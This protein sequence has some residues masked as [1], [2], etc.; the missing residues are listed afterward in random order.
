MI[1][2]YVSELIRLFVETNLFPK[3]ELQD[4]LCMSEE[5]MDGLL[6]GSDNH[7]DLNNIECFT[8]IFGMSSLQYNFLSEIMTD[9]YRYSET[10][11]SLSTNKPKV[12]RM[13]SKLWAIYGESNNSLQRGIARLASNKCYVSSCQLMMDS[14]KDAGILESVPADEDSDNQE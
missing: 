10:H 8:T 14:L 13:L 9:S 3:E 4:M 7:L 2:R 5:A 12:K 6:Q 11:G 1:T